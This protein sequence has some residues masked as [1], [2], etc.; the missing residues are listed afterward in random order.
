MPM[1]IGG[2]WGY[3]WFSGGADPLTNVS[4]MNLRAA[5][6]YVATNRDDSQRK[7]RAAARHSLLVRFLRFAIPAGVLV[8]VLA[9]FVVVKVLDPLRELMKLPID[10]GGLVVSGT[11]IVMQ[12][13]RLAGFTKDSRPYVVTARAAA[14]DVTKP[15]QLEL[16]DIRATIDMKDNGAVEVLAHSGIFE[17]KADRL[18]L[19]R[20]IQI[21]SATYQAHLSEAVVN[22]KLGH[23]VSEKPVEIT[24]LKGTINANRFEII[25]SGEI[26][27]FEQGVTMVLTMDAAPPGRAAG[28]Q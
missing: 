14:Q 15:D 19:Q 28:S 26:V 27:R 7:Y 23:V 2:K 13:P 9:A 3:A 18:M 24:M 4:Q 21:N 10:I 12:Q 25:N 5:Q 6:G 1:G 22:I 20:S 8:G 17:T 11:K 16:E